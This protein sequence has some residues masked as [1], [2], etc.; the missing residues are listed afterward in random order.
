MTVSVGT[1]SEWRDLYTSQGVQK[2][3]INEI[4]TGIN[5][6]F[7]DV[8][9]IHFNLSASVTPAE[10]DLYWNATDKTLNIKTDTETVI[11]IG[12]EQ[13]LRSKNNTGVQINNGEVL[14]ISGAD[15]ARPE[16]TLANANSWETSQ[17]T[18][19]IATQD[20]ANGAEGF[21]TTFGLVRDL[22]TSGMAEGAI[23]Y[24]GTTDGEFTTT[25]PSHPDF[26]VRVGFI[27]NVDA[28]DGIIFFS[29]DHDRNESF[30]NGTFN[31][32]FDALVTSNGTIITMSL[33]RSGGG[34]L[35][36]RFSDGPSTLDT[37][38]AL[39][40]VLTAGTDTT[41]VFNYIY[42]PQS[43][44]V[45]TKS[46]SGF[47]TATEHIKVGSFFVQSATRVQSKGVLINQNHND[48]GAG[49]DLMGHMAHVSERIRHEGAVFVSGLAGAGSS[50][51]LTLALNSTLFSVDAGVIYQMHR[52]TVPAFDQNAGDEVLIVNDSVTAYLASS[53][54]YNDITADSTGA[55]ISNN[56]YFNL[57]FIGVGNKSGEYSPVLCN[58]PA[59]SYNTQA[60][61]EQDTNGYDNFNI[62]SEF[63]IESSTGFLICRLTIRMG[64]TWTYVSTVDLR[65]TTPQSA[66]GGGVGGAVTSFNDSQFDIHNTADPTKVM[67]FDVSGIT[68]ATTRT[69]TMPDSNVTLHNIATRAS[70]GIDTSN[71][72]QFAKLGIGTAAVPHGGIGGALVAIEGVNANALTGPNLQFTTAT[73]DYP[74]MQ[75]LNFT[76]DNIRISF[77]AYYDGSDKSSDPGS[78][79]RIIKVSDEL[80]FDYDSGIAA[81]STVT[82][83]TGFK[84]DTSGNITVPSTAGGLVV[85]TV[86]NRGA[87]TIAANDIHAKIFRAADDVTHNIDMDPSA[88]EMHIHPGDQGGDNY[89]L[90]SSAGA[91]AGN[92]QIY[93]NVAGEGQIGDATLQWRDIRGVNI[94]KNG[95]ALDEHD[96]LALIDA[97]D[98]KKN[99]DGTTFRNTDNNPIIDPLSCPAFMR[100][101]I[102]VDEWLCDYDSQ[103]FPNG[104]ALLEHL[105]AEH[106]AIQAKFEKKD[107]LT[108]ST[109]QERFT[110]NYSNS[111]K[112]LDALALGGVKQLNQ[113]LKDQ[114]QTILLLVDR[115]TVLEKN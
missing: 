54:L 45:L 31:E 3:K 66:T 87:T 11:Q 41:P 37:D 42:I 98:V 58:L 96:D 106:T 13:V 84:L 70:L 69:I 34:E 114:E 15:T 62:P 20:I 76:H 23:V 75:I 92:P 79:Y 93:P 90:M 55:A 30:F 19:G 102:N 83:N 14:F 91:G 21:V 32:S 39:T 12:Q 111:I 101:P 44:K 48:H 40:I 17:T 60:G 67:V 59:G 9:V 100:D 71:T 80:S 81:G 89:I 94:Y 5:N 104:R 110:G 56:K 24:L 46:T 74:L 26:V 109:Y 103:I 105:N 18:I 57:V 10:G 49:T 43:T 52:H 50:D 65:G 77:D 108:H 115:I 22:D 27:T 97:M 6:I 47:P 16:I 72:V 107:I 29:V 1:V 33:E 112:D 68:T 8:D 7:V 28:S 78:N 86:T 51:Y 82:W 63:N 88:D 38:P 53:D 64:T 113:K 99:L 36:M 4:I 95:S 35:T 25:R 61:A 73:N 2:T 85:G